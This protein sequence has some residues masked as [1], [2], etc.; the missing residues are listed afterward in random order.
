[1]VDKIVCY[2]D[3]IVLNFRAINS[4]ELIVMWHFCENGQH[5]VS[6]KAVGVSLSCDSND[7]YF[8]PFQLF[9]YNDRRHNDFIH[10]I[11]PWKI[12]PFQKHAIP[13]HVFQ[14]HRLHNLL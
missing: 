12:D 5:R 8:P 3:K 9:E 7:S 6:I 1:M 13:N 2:L 10:I 4:L 11:R 14:Y